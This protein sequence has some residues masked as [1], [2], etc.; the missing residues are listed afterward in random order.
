MSFKEITLQ[1]YLV[2]VI[3]RSPTNFFRILLIFIDF[4]YFYR[5]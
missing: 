1:S 3:N 2:R 5:Y 4:F